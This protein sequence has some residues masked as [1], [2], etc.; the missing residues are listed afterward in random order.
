MFKYLL[1]CVA[2]IALL[3]SGGAHSGSTDIIPRAINF[4][5]FA[6]ILYYYIAEPAKQWYLGRKNEIADKLDSIQV[7][8][9]ESHS[10]KETALAKVEEA[11]VNARALIETAK[12]EAVLLSEKVSLEA[13]QEITNLEKAFQDRATIERRKMQRVIVSEILDEVF[14]EGSISLDN[15]EIVKIVSK[16]VA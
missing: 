15:N 16:K 3:A 2:P 6:A 7:K 4:L 5:I 10:K 11:K 12:K 14:Q 9:K 1:M 13:D 8:L